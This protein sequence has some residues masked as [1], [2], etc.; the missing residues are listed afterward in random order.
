MKKT[1]NC[2][3]KKGLRIGLIM[4][5]AAGPLAA[6]D[7]GVN[8]EAT[9][10]DSQVYTGERVTLKL[11]VTSNGS[12][13]VSR[14][15]MPIVDGLRNI[16]SFPS[17]STSYSMVNGVSTMSYSYSWQLEAMEE[18]I[19]EIA[20][21]SVVINGE[22]YQTNPVSITVLNE[23]S[24]PGQEE[25]DSRPD[26][27]L[28]MEVSDTNPVRGQQIIAELVIYFKNDMDLSSYQVSQ[29]WVTEG[30][31]QEDLNEHHS[32]RAENVLLEGVRYR[33]AVLRK[34]AL[35]PTR[36][37]DLK[38]QPYKI[39]ANVRY[40]RSGNSN[41]FGGFRNST[42]NIDLES[43]ELTIFVQDLPPA[44][45]GLFINAV[46]RLNVERS[47]SSNRINLGESVEILTEISGSGNIALV[48]RPDYT[49]PSAF[50][51]YQPQE[52]IDLDKRNGRISGKKTFRDVIIA[53]KVGRYELPETRIAMYNDNSHRYE[54]VT[55]PPLSMEVVRDPNAEIGYVSDGRFKVTPVTGVVRWSSSG[56]EKPLYR[57]WWFW[58]GLLLPL[59][60]LGGAYRVK[61]HRDK[62]NNDALFSRKQNAAIR[63][64]ASLQAAREAISRYDLKTPYT[65]IHQGLADFIT[66]RCGLPPSGHSDSELTGFIRKYGVQESMAADIQKLL[67]KCST[68]R[69]APVSN[70]DNVTN[71]IR[72]AEVFIAKL[73]K[74]I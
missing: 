45:G 42:R 15:D 25:V 35:F 49:F 32:A 26:V 64:A 19:H 12:K 10:S 30:F 5:I 65:C 50:D 69:Y 43:E 46:G 38:L 9:V 62:L 20:P 56:G 1:G 40:A 73:G 29:G 66:D 74:C 61:V 71:D 27:F 28:K 22:T 3:Y 60:I 63:A 24:R 4:L 14:P 37:G 13:N 39:Q 72:K 68:I 54:T 8:V 17:T 51:V 44:P 18:G 59:F 21:V 2:P 70:A 47:L 41:Y 55:L 31:W 11:E 34:H 58:A 57:T 6:Q 36:K 7:N 48:S 52:S 33:R 67:E 23:Q 53:R 16:S